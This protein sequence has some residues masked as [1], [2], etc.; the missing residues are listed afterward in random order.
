MLWRMRDFYPRDWVAQEPFQCFGLHEVTRILTRTSLRWTLALW[1]FHSVLFHVSKWMPKAA[2]QVPPVKWGTSAC[3]LRAWCNQISKEGPSLASWRQRFIDTSI[4]NTAF[5]A[6]DPVTHAT[7]QSFAQM[8][9]DTNVPIFVGGVDI[10]VSFYAIGQLEAFQ[11]IF[12]LDPHRSMG[13]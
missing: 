8:N 7:R 4:P 5:E 11:D 9:V 13:G 10:Q 1:P 3:S 2:G 12:A 6:R